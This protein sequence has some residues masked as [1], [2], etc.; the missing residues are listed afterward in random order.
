MGEGEEEKGAFE[1]IGL[2][3]PSA[4]SSVYDAVPSQDVVDRLIRCEAHLSRE[5]DRTLSQLER[6]Q[7]IRLGHAVPPPLRLE[8][9]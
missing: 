3:L 9:R 6:L 4:R 2:D 1:R 8:I 5:I 7:R